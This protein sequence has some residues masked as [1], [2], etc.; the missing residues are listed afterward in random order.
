M[1]EESIQSKR[2]EIWTRLY[3]R[4]DLNPGAPVSGG[5]GRV[6]M[7]IRPVISVDAL[8]ETAEIRT[9][10]ESQVVGTVTYHVVPEDEKWWL[11][12]YQASVQAGNRDVS[13]IVLRSPSALG[14]LS[15]VVDFFTPAA[16]RF[17]MLPQRLPV[18][19]GWSIRMTGEGGSTN[20][21]WTMVIY[22]AVEQS[23]TV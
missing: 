18:P 1:M 19:A 10:T 3:D 5:R 22:I 11:Y 17:L 4:L 14:A 16:N 8:L 6:A 2:Q 12:G 23:F 9:E 20:G 15:M 13:A 21:N 7:M